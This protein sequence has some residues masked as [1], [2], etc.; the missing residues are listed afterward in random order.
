MDGNTLWVGTRR[1]RIFISR[2]ASS[3]GPTYARIDTDAQPNRLPSGIAVDP[4]NP[5]HA[6]ITYSGYNAYAVASGTAP[7][8]VFEV[9]VNPTTLAAT[10]KLL[11]Y[12]LGDQP[13][14]DVVYDQPTG[15]LYVGTD[16]G[17]DRL[18]AGGSSWIT[19]AD[20]MPPVAVYGLT[21]AKVKNGKRVIYAATHGRG[22]YRLDL[23]K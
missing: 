1:G 2:D 17:V 19:A 18:P 23:K 7:G 14:T 8:H 9:T 6:F 4:T 16:W 13:I 21:Y 20:G 22:A 15:D 11:D 5:L 3:A 12:N 10:W